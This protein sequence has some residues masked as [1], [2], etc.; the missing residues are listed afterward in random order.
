MR[1][2]TKNFVRVLFVGGVIAAGLAFNSTS[3]YAAEIEN[4]TVA[5]EE[6]K[7]SAIETM[8]TA[9]EVIEG[10]AVAEEGYLDQ[11]KDAIEDK[12][13]TPDSA[14]EILSDGTEVM[15]QA[16][17]KKETVDEIYDTVIT[18][19]EEA[20]KNFEQ[21]ADNYG[22]AEDAQAVE[23]AK[24]D[25]E[26]IDRLAETAEDAEAK[27][28]EFSK[29]E[30]KD[31]KEYKDVCNEISE[32]EEVVADAQTE[33]DDLV[34]DYEELNGKYNELAKYFDDY[35]KESARFDSEIGA[36]Q[37]EINDLNKALGEFSNVVAG[38]GQNY[39]QAV[40]SVNDV[41]KDLK[42]AESNMETAAAHLEK[43]IED[44]EETEYNTDT[45]AY[46]TQL[47]NFNNTTQIVN[48]RSEALQ[49]AKSQY[50]EIKVQ[51]A[52]KNQVIEEKGKQLSNLKTQYNNWL[53]DNPYDEKKAEYDA[54]G[55]QIADVTA[56]KDKKESSLSLR[57]GYLDYLENIKAGIDA[58]IDLELKNYTAVA[59]AITRYMDALKD[60][61][62][63]VD[64]KK[65]ADDG[66]QQTSESY[67]EL[68]T[69]VKEYRSEAVQQEF[70]AIFEALNTA[71]GEVEQAAQTEQTYETQAKA[72]VQQNILTPYKA[73]QLDSASDAVIVDARKRNED[74]HKYYNQLINR[75]EEEAQAPDSILDM[76]GNGKIDESESSMVV[77]MVEYIND[78]VAKSDAQLKKANDSYNAITDIYTAYNQDVIEIDNEAD[79]PEWLV[80]GAS[81][82][83]VH[84]IGKLKG[85]IEKLAMAEE[86]DEFLDNIIAISGTFDVKIK[87]LN[88]GAD[89]VV[90]TVDATGEEFRTYFA[91]G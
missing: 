15:E 82:V 83:T 60:N 21:A 66:F 9:V 29:T 45:S 89:S 80:D 51:Y 77:T 4:Q 86:L 28:D 57:K 48:Q 65:R 17:E 55:E 54:T 26:K 47:E 74:V 63:A 14:K 90:Q 42:K 19:T 33:Y 8:E 13:I 38:Y 50:E 37:E 10:D 36:L 53:A 79:Y 31:S 23:A 91:I 34:K 46:E 71:T 72:A 20:E 16:Q 39:A 3:S 30:G 41:M 32:W 49:E 5:A 58:K 69:V 78:I 7:S 62:A 11:A 70:S 59:D 22:L 6:N 64:L 43:L 27:Y 61:I 68:K 67:Q 24:T 1:E 85:N 52:S 81:K 44:A 84:F 40:A 76:N 12:T 56:K 87:Y 35:N 73:D 75:L 18:K 2:R 25:Q 88:G